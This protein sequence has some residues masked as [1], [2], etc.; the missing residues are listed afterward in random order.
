MDK[1]LSKSLPSLQKSADLERQ[2]TEMLSNPK[3]TAGQRAKIL[4]KLTA[5]NNAAS[6]AEA[7]ALRHSSKSGKGEQVRARFSSIARTWPDDWTQERINE[8]AYP[9]MRERQR[10]ASG[11][12]ITY[13]SHYSPLRRSDSTQ[14]A[15]LDHFER[16]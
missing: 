13:P 4:G 8:A 6:R 2:L 10:I 12:L 5:L 7:S 15:I 1:N 3:L 16:T 9:I 11:G 14:Q